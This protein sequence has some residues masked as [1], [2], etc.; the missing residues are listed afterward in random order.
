MS[1]IRRNY[2]RRILL[3]D[4]ARAA[5]LS[6]YH[7]HRLFRA[8]FGRTAKRAMAELQIGEAQRLL[9]RGLTPRQVAKRLGFAHQ[10]HFTSRFKQFTGTTPRRWMRAT[11]DVPVAPA[12]YATQYGIGAERA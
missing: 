1:F 3:A 4:I 9:K 12:A 6:P 10:S 8:H 7:F 5:A 2:H 11:A